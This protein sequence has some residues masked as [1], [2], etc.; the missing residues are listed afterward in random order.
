MVSLQ[1]GGQL[2]ILVGKGDG[3]NIWVWSVLYSLDSLC[4]LYQYC[5]SAERHKN[6]LR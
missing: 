5:N 3:I 2:L 6:M 4:Y 1:G